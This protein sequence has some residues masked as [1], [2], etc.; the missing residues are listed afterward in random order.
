MPSWFTEGTVAVTN[1][2]AVVTGT[3]TKFS[4]CRAGDMFVGPDAGIYQVINPLS[5]TSLSIAPAYR[6]STSTGAGYGIVPVNGYPKAL[7]DA[8]NLMVQQWGATLAGLGTVSTENVVPVAKGGTGGATQAAARTGLGLGTAATRTVGTAATNLM[9]VGAGGWLGTTAENATTINDYKTSFKLIQ[10]STAGAADLGLQYGGMLT[11]C[12]D[13]A[14][15]RISQLFFGQVPGD[16]LKFRSG[17]AGTAQILKIY[18]TGNTTRA[19]D[20]T[21][22]AI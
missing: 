20:G 2:N 15:N 11:L 17:K 8:V 12:Y 21:L 14:D 22:K 3:G 13:A 1:G 6:G 7:A 9:E 16:D 18:H 4:N 10:P 5:D 19:Q